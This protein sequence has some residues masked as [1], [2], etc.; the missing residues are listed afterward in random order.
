[1]VRISRFGTNW[2]T[3]NK[4]KT[5]KKLKDSMS[6]VNLVKFI[7]GKPTTSFLKKKKP[8]RVVTG[9][10]KTT[11]EKNTLNIVKIKDKQK[12]KTKKPKEPFKEPVNMTTK[13]GG[14][15]LF[16][17]DKIKD[18]QKNKTK[19]PKE[20]FK[21]PVNMTTKLGGKSLF[22][23]DKIKDKQK[24]SLTRD[25]RLQ[26]IKDHKQSRAKPISR[27]QT[28]KQRIVELKSNYGKRKT[29]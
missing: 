29:K 23:I 18:K 1:M 7:Q 9:K 2:L 22:G 16:G 24:M 4:P 25:K 14:K 8:E 21:E 17:I 27:E 3:T 6:E 19:K 13:L 10:L 11:V 28:K 12:N 20:P 5:A 26:A 15:S